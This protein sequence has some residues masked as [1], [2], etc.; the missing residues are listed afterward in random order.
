[1]VV[2]AIIT[3]LAGMLLS[4]LASAKSKSKTTYC[5][6]N[7]HQLAMATSLY[8]SD[9]RDSFPY[10]GDFWPPTSVSD[11]WSLF[12]SA[13]STNR[14]FYVCPVDRGP[15]NV[16]WAEKAGS[17]WNPPL[18]TNQL[19]VASSYY[20]FPSFY[21]ED[22][23]LTT[24]RQRRSEDVVH[25]SQKLL[26]I[27][28]AVSASTQINGNNLAPQGHGNGWLPFLFVDGHARFLKTVNWTRDPRISGR[29]LEWSGLD[30]IDIGNP[31][32]VAGGELII[33]SP[34]LSQSGS[35][36]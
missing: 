34:V 15:F 21:Y 2:V 36:L 16:L 23:P 7:L 12:T 33:V 30:W 13:I 11:V 5:I 24:L 4:S 10:T 9:N 3:I 27:C 31:L 25:P 32:R 29:G 6:S 17:I 8:L 19:S 26:M 14:T 35:R 18:R 28:A 20:Y 1:L 22:P